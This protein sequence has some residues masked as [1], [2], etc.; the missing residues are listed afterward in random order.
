[1][2]FT[3]K[4]FEDLDEIIARYIQPIAANV[5][6]IMAFKYYRDSEGGKRDILD[7]ILTEEKNKA[8]Y[9]IPYLLSASK[10]YPG[11]FFLSYMPRNVVRHEYVSVRPDGIKCGNYIF[12]SV[13]S[14]IRWFKEHF[15][16]PVPGCTNPCH[17]GLLKE[18]QNYQKR[19]CLPRRL[20]IES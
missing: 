10:Q 11:K 8:R 17:P 2:M 19:V 16:D 9:K 7:K 3:S 13:N 18:G 12:K 20:P 15:K 6:D 4:E 14:M 5:R 1:M